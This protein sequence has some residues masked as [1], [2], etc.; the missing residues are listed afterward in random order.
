MQLQHIFKRETRAV[1]IDGRPYTFIK[2]LPLD[3]I[4]LGHIPFN[5]F[6][7]KTSGGGMAASMDDME[8]IEEEEETNN[9]DKIYFTIFEKAIQN[10]DYEKEL[11]IIGVKGL[12]A[13]ANEIIYFSL[14]H[15]TNV[16][17]PHR[18]IL[19]SC[20][21]LAMQF[22]GNPFDYLTGSIDSFL[23]NQISFNAGLKE[24][25]RL[26]KIEESKRK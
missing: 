20:Y 13:L 5:V 17:T 23:F 22:G 3:F 16:T 1:N 2:L 6:N 14:S 24:Q 25:K 26:D 12:E 8:E 18:S 10:F 19:L 15:V 11:S 4:E 7:I 21:S 9:S